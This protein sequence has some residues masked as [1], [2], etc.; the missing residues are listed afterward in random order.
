MSNEPPF[1]DDDL[2]NDFY[3]EPD[4]YPDE[5]DIPEEY[6]EELQKDDNHKVMNE[7]N[8][9]PSGNVDLPLNQD[10]DVMMEESEKPEVPSHVSFDTNEVQFKSHKSDLYSFER[11]SGKQKWRTE[12]KQEGDVM[13][14]VNWKTQNSK[15]S[16]VQKT[17]VNTAPEAQLIQFSN[18]NEFYNSERFQIN[19]KMATNESTF[20]TIDNDTIPVNVSRDVQY[21]RQQEKPVA[22]ASLLGI[23]M[24]ELIKRAD[25]LERKKDRQKRQKLD[26]V[27]HDNETMENEHVEHGVQQHRNE[28]KDRLWVDKHSPQN[29]SDL[30]SDERI[31]REVL[32]SLRAWDPYVFGKE[33]PKRPVYFQQQ[34][35]DQADATTTTPEQTNDKRPDLKN[36][37]I[38]LSGP[39]GV[40]KTTLAHIIAKHAGYRPIEVNASDERSASVLTERVTRAMESSTLNISS[41]GK[42][43]VMAGRPNCLILDEVDGAD[44]KSSINA[45][46]NII[47]ADK[48][49]PNAKKKATYLRRPIIFICNHKHAPALRP[50]LPYAKCFDVSPPSA[51]R[52][53]SRLKA[54]LSAERMTLVG[55]GS[56]LHRL[57]EGSGGDIRSCLFTLQFAAAR[58]REMALNKQKKNQDMIGA[59]DVLVDITAAL[60]NALGGNGLGLKDQRSDM[61]G[62][63]MKIFKKFKGKSKSSRDVER[64][65]QAADVFGDNSKILDSF[66]M[67]IANI[68]YVDPTLDRC[69]TAHEWLSCVDVFR[70]FKTSVASNN[71]SEHR[72]MQKWHIPSAIAA[73]HLLCRVETRP[74][75]QLSMRE[76]TDARYQS[77]ANV[78]L[79]DKFLEGLPPSVKSGINK[80]QLVSDILPY[81][82]WLL[83]SGQGIGSLNRA[84]SSLDVLKKEEKNAFFAHVQTLR[85]LG[86]TYV[87]D[88]DD[89][90]DY[91]TRV[92][93]MR[94]EPEI[95]RVSRYKGVSHVRGKIPPLMKELLAHETTVAGLRAKEEG[96]EANVVAEEKDD[97]HMVNQEQEKNKKE[98]QESNKKQ[99]T[100][101]NTSSTSTIPSKKLTTKDPKSIPKKKA[102]SNFLGIG[103]ARAKAART[104]RKAA[105]VG[106]DRSKGRVKYSNTGSGIIID[107]VIRFK[108][109]KGFTQA[110]RLPCTKR[111]LFC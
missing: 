73:C 64:I 53:V 58:A 100:S 89:S 23:T 12:M 18:K 13:E 101:P 1:N 52:F 59:N 104:A 43:D 22:D 97:V 56:M 14:A 85:S 82:L 33:P 26:A 28:E 21:L 91:G 6:M 106:F 24:K 111:D 77:E 46:V 72:T 54:V 35:A 65:L 78:G 3:E 47:K 34:Q 61:G 48:P 19:K 99:V 57:V 16:I 74:D 44:A 87:K 92:M 15:N 93:N 68:S 90:R 11:Y 71:V 8:Q 76:I 83:S 51:N 70:S 40:G 105:Q 39:A 110:V 55:G 107:K 10:N 86:L 27:D 109:Q 31:N 108:Y 75:I 9:P 96:R 32:R 5:F 7:K 37:V 88:E 49:D 50:L 60:S 30:L 79:V 67:N 20:M 17:K 94:L 62:T 2:I 42:K 95:D 45:L 38:L 80:H 98:D 102:A 4:E 84:V 36:R 29:F 63:L 25:A 69:W 66:F 41:I 81:C 103:A